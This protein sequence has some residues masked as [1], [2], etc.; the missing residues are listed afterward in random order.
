MASCGYGVL[1]QGR[2]FGLHG[3]GIFVYFDTQSDLGY[4]LEAVQVPAERH[5]PELI[6]P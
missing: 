5:E 4:L 2:G 1:Q 3:D 6:I